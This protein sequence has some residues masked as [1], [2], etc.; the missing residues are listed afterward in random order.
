MSDSLVTHPFTPH[1]FWMKKALD[2][3][4][5]AFDQGEVPVGAIIVYQEKVI[6]E[7]CNQREL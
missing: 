7:A 4:L 3:A 1:D 5:L 6:A 2:Q